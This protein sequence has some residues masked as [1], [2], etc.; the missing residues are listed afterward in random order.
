MVRVD[1]LCGY[2]VSPEQLRAFANAQSI[3]Y[4]SGGDLTLGSDA[5]SKEE[6]SLFDTFGKFI[7]LA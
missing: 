3:R 1:I 2:L 6:N 4:D 7:T 5:G